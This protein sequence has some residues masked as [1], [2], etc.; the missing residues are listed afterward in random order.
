MDIRTFRPGDEV[1]QVGIYNEAAASL[2]KFKPATVDELR[3]RAIGPDFDAN[4]RFFAVVQGRPVAY[5]TFHP[6]NGRVS[7]PWCRAGYESAA[8]PLLD[9][10]LAEM[11]ARQLPRAFAAYRPDW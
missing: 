10:A 1:A 3:R 11:T 8:Q 6:H 5:M 7:Y 4:T 9:R 2:P